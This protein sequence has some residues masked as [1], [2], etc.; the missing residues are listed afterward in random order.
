MNQQDLRF[1]LRRLLLQR[2]DGVHLELEDTD[3]MEIRRDSAR[4]NITF[5]LTLAMRARSQCEIS[6]F[7]LS[8]ASDGEAM[9]AIDAEI[10]CTAAR[11]R[12][13]LVERLIE[14]ADQAP[15][16]FDADPDKDLAARHRLA[17]LLG[18]RSEGA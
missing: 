2:T 16:R 17:A 13:Q 9:D 7:Q 6:V 4:D 5:V 14:Q 15:I 12:G 10:G 1:V 18:A 11:L 3:G 8:R